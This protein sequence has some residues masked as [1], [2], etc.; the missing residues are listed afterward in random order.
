MQDP[1][2][3]IQAYQPAQ[4]QQLFERIVLEAYSNDLSREHHRNPGS[5][6]NFQLF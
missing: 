6:F 3:E 1:T 2:Y 4:S 5:C